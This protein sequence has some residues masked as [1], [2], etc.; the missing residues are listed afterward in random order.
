MSIFK[1]GSTWRVDLKFH[2]AGEIANRITRTF[3]TKTEALA[4][5][6]K[7][8]HAVTDARKAGRR[9]PEAKRVDQVLDD[10]WSEA[11]G[12]MSSNYRLTNR[13]RKET[14]K[15]Q[16]LAK[17]LIADL[18]IVHLEDW[19]QEQRDQDLT[20]STIRNNL[21]VLSSMF[22]HAKKKWK[23][24][25]ENPVTEVLSDIGSSIKRDRRLSEEEFEQ[26]VKVFALMRQRQQDAD[27]VLALDPEAHIT[28][29]RSEVVDDGQEERSI[30]LSYNPVLLYISAA[31]EAS[32]EAAMRRGKTFLMKWSWIDWNKRMIL[33]PFDHQGPKNKVVPSRIP[34][35]PALIITLMEL[36]GM[37]NGSPIR[38]SSEALK[39][40]V[41]G[42]LSADRAYRLLKLA[43]ELLQIEDLRWHDLRHEA[44]SRLAE[45][46]WTV[47]QIQVVSGHKTL[48]SLQRYMHIRPESIHRLWGRQDPNLLAA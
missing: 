23:W 39:E 17:R 7:T 33:V 8:Q 14:W 34:A 18:T 25:L 29:K 26:L 2:R 41:F 1:R 13:Y 6:R 20:E 3:D 30:R 4:F 5:E 43:C 21:F 24:Q 36:N 48:Q 15:K 40:P 31:F 42:D 35:S 19:V 44:C 22:K 45:L 11:E 16:P 12:S 37:Q 32:I 28:I 10:W 27:R 46:G 38:R 9:L 47:Q